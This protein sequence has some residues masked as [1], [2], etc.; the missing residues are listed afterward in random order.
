MLKSGKKYEELKWIIKTMKKPMAGPKLKQKNC[1]R[2][3]FSFLETQAEMWKRERENVG[4]RKRER[5][6][7]EVKK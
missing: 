3:F 7:F 5:E 1:D 4:K 2:N 6:T